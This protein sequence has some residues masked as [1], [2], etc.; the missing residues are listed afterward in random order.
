MVIT[1]MVVITLVVLYNTI[2]CEVSFTLLH[3]AIIVVIVGV[4]VGCKSPTS[5]IVT[6]RIFSQKVILV[7]D[8]MHVIVTL[9]LLNLSLRC[10]ILRLTQI[11]VAWVQVFM[12]LLKSLI[13]AYCTIFVALLVHN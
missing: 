11:V 3:H 13:V 4:G 10:S 6:Y 2:V 7:A 9:N 12:Q 8:G 1:M 5:L